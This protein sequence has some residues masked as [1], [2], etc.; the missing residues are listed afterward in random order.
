[1]EESVWLGARVS[2]PDAPN[3]LGRIWQRGTAGWTGS[4]TIGLDDGPHIVSVIL[5]T[6]LAG[7]RLTVAVDGQAIDSALIF[8]YLGEIRKFVWRG[9]QF[10]LRVKGFGMSGEL[11]LIMDKSELAPDTPPVTDAT[12]VAKAPT[13][14]EAVV[15]AQTPVFQREINIVESDE[16]IG[17]E[18]YPLDNGFGDSALTTDRQISKASTNECSVETT[19]QVNANFSGQV[20]SVIKAEI[21]GQLSQQTGSKIGETV[22]ESQTLHLSVGPHAAVLYRVLWKRRVR[23]GQRVY[24]VDAAE[25]TVPYRITYGLTC[26]V[27]SQE[28]KSTN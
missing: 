21:A 4:W 26:E 23:A 12:A 18:E 25:V 16:V 1:M 19:G 6:G 5:R 2:E 28:L 14:R 10:A 17:V 3:T 11:V 15:N 27:R 7:N 9:H 22:T 13:V 8:A 20:L 24:S